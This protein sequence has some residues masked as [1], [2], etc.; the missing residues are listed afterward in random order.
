M[1]YR[2]YER[3]LGDVCRESVKNGQKCDQRKQRIG[4]G[5][6][7][8]LHGS[9][10]THRVFLNALRRTF[11]MAQ[12]RPV[13]CVEIVHR[14]SPAKNV[15]TDDEA[16]NDEQR[17][18]HQA[19]QR[20]DPEESV[21]FRSLH[22][23]R[24]TYCLLKKIEEWTAPIVERDIDLHVYIGGKK[25]KRRN[26]DGPILPWMRRVEA[27]EEVEGCEHH[28]EVDVKPQERRR[29]EHRHAKHRRRVRGRWW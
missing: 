27:P 20:V 11:D 13:L 26:Q 4:E 8:L 24:R 18:E 16:R 12:S 5:D 14:R 2:A 1:G 21:E 15:V 28:S 17:D 3:Q 9:G 22:C 25:N 19:D 7:Q 29:P 10:K 23:T 6:T